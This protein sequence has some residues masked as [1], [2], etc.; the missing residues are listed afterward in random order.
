[1]AAVEVSITGRDSGSDERTVL[2]REGRGLGKFTIAPAR[3]RA[4]VLM[5][6]LARVSTEVGFEMAL[7]LGWKK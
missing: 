2:L 3:L 5:S 1:M 6:K 7:N 4:N